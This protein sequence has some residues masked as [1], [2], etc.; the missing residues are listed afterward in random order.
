MTIIATQSALAHRILSMIQNSEAAPRK[1][2]FIPPSTRYYGQAAPAIPDKTLPWNLLDSS[3]KNE[4]V[5]L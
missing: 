2:S 5:L 1:L 3:T 4:A